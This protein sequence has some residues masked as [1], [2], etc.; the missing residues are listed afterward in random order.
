MGMGTIRVRGR[1]HVQ[2]GPV[3]PARTMSNCLMGI[4]K[5]QWYS[6]GWEIR[7]VDAIP[8]R[9]SNRVMACVGVTVNRTGAQPLIIRTLPYA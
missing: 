8:K 2:P 5:S 6:L 7:V 1:V 4:F 9:V 3:W